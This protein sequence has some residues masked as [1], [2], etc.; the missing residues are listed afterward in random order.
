M[1]MAHALR[2]RITL[3]ILTAPPWQESKLS[4]TCHLV[5][6]EPQSK[7]PNS[8]SSLMRLALSRMLSVTTDECS[9]MCASRVFF[10]GLTLLCESIESGREKFLDGF[11]PRELSGG[12]GDS[13]D[14]ASRP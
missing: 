3:E 8:R 5:A 14:C 10:E 6:A 7:Q 1:E 2:R 9:P 4:L 12:V 11:D 13:G